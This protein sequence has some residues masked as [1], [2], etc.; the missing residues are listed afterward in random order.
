MISF[1][2][3]DSCVQKSALFHPEDFWPRGHLGHSD[4]VPK[5]P[6]CKVELFK[7]ISETLSTKLRGLI[8]KRAELRKEAIMK[9]WKS[10][11]GFEGGWKGFLKQS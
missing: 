9:S 5:E 10:P 4:L 11:R 7:Q 3:H 1:D 8:S 6:G 2:A